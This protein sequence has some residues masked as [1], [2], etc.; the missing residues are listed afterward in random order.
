VEYDRVR[1]LKFAGVLH[2]VGEEGDLRQRFI[3]PVEPQVEPMRTI[4]LEVGRDDQAERL[5]APVD[6]RAISAHHEAGRGGPRRLAGG[7]LGGA[8]LADLQQVPRRRDLRG[9][10][11][12]VV[13]DRK[14][15]GLRKHE[16]VR[17]ER[18]VLDLRS[19]CLQMRERS[20]QFRTIGVG[21]GNSV[22][23]NLLDGLLSEER[24]RGQHHATFS[25]LH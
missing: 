6:F 20:G 5:N 22:G 4:A 9:L 7:K 14:P 1:R 24:H 16:H 21:H 25:N 23:R 15:H 13:V 8:L 12:L 19:R 17:R 2:T 18:M 11:E 3:A 10:E